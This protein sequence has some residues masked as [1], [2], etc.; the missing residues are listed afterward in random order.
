MSDAGRRIFKMETALGVLANQGGADV[1]DF[2]G[3]VISRSVDECCRPAVA[4][5]AKG[6]LYSMNPEFMKVPFDGTTSFN[7]WCNEQKGRLG[8]NVSLEPM[9]AAEVAGIHTLMDTVEAA[10]QDA[11]DKAAEA[12]AALEAQK[13]AEANAKAMAPFKAKAEELEKKVAQLEEKNKGLA[14]ELAEEKAKSAAFSGKV[15]IDEK[16]IEKTLKDIITR[17]VGSMSFAA[18]AAAGTA[19]AEGAAAEPAAFDA[20]TDSAGAVPDTFGFGASGASDD[21]FGF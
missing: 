18:G 5:M 17:T 15:A 8:D 9:P 6:W 21:G 10:L 11:Q 2:L 20:P 13:A 12:A 1:L 16:E 19:G 7:A 4:P 3:F 14:G